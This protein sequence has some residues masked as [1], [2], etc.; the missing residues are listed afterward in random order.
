MI[1]DAGWFL[2]LMFLWFVMGCVLC[3]GCLTRQEHRKCISVLNMLGQLYVLPHWDRSSR[4][5][6]VSGCLNS[7]VGSVFG[8]LSYVM[9]CCGFDPD[10][11][12]PVEG[13][14]PC[15]VNMGSDSFPPKLVQ[16]RV[17][18]LRSSLC[19]RAFHGTDSQDPDVHVLDRWMLAA[20]AHPACTIH[21]ECDYLKGWIKNSPIHK[22]LTQRGEPQQLSWECRRRR[23]NLFSHRVTVFWHPANLFWLWPCKC[24]A[25]LWCGDTSLGG[26][27]CWLVAYYLRVT[28]FWHPANQFQLWPLSPDTWQDIHWSTN[29]KSVVD[30]TREGKGSSLFVP[31]SHWALEEVG[32]HRETALARRERCPPWALGSWGFKS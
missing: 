29:I 4:S 14:F 12:L 28:V 31:P 32:W 10:S 3:F 18:T 9:Q 7:S 22:S 17:Y 6:L 21:K 20:K 19:T 16:M 30:S 23:R 27:C 26:G 25:R 13:F 11:E 5:S 8:L 2:L 24:I 15:G 1:G